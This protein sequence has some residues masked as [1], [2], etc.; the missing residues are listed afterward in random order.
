MQVQ[1]WRRR[2]R[3]AVLAA[4]TAPLIV[5]VVLVPFRISF[6]NTN[7]ALV[8]VAVVVAVAARCGR[9][10]HVNLLAVAGCVAVLGLH[11]PLGQAGEQLVAVASADPV[12]DRVA[13]DGAGDAGHQD[14]GQGQ[15]VLV[16]QDTAEH[17]P[18]L[19]GDH[20]ADECRRLKP[21][22]QEH[23]GERHGGRQAQD[24][25]QQVTHR[26]WFPGRLWG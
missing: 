18:D 20:H 6:A 14:G 5:T 13:Q 8:L 7:A 19:A 11:H 2:D 17:D 16:G 3:L 15:L 10:G 23:E 24:A 9:P 25:I 22:E 12:A 26:L 21:G 4:I 1:P